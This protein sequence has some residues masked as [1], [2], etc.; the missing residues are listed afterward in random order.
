MIAVSCDITN[1][2][3][4]LFSFVTIH[5]SDGWTDR[6]RKAIPLELD[7]L[8]LQRVIANGLKRYVTKDYF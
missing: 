4:A 2:R 1:I 7:L 6:I 8:K 3:S 5:A